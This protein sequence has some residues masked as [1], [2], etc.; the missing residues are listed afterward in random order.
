MDLTSAS[1]ELSFSG[2][3]N[4]TELTIALG[5]QTPGTTPDP[6]CVCNLHQS[7]WQCRIL[8]PLSEARDRTHNLLV[9]SRIR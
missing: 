8:N 2:L 1:K 6:S 5:E 3:E 9:P 4:N 7:S